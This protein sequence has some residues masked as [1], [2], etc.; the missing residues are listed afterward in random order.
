MLRN[1]KVMKA[2][3]NGEYAHT[4]RALFLTSIF[5]THLLISF[6]TDII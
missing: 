2:G 6:M 1:L 3:Y 4:F 5:P